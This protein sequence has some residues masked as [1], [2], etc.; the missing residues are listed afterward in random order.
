MNHKLWRNPSIYSRTSNESF[1]D[2][3]N[4]AIR[5]AK[6]KVCAAYQYIN[7]EPVDLNVIFENNSY[8]T[9][10]DEDLNKSIQFFEY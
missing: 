3:Y 10:I 2:L 1:D 9:G 6:V 8:L 5:I 7:G 4:K